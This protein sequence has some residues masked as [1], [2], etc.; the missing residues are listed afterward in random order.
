VDTKLWTGQ[1]AITFRNWDFI[2]HWSFGFSPRVRLTFQLRFHTQF[3]QSILLTG[4]HELFGNQDIARALPLEYLDPQFWRVTIS[5][6][7]HAAPDADI[8]YNYV[9]RN[10]DGSLIY[11]WGNDKVI[12]PAKVAA[13]ELLIIDS[14]NHAGFYENAF[15]T[16]PFRR[17]LLKGNH[18]EVAVP[19]PPVVTHT[20][21]VKEPLVEKGQTVCLLGNSTAL[22]NWDTT[23]PLLLGRKQDENFFTLGLDLSGEPFPI[24]Y[25]YGVYDP[26]RQAF[27]RYEEGANRVL[28]DQPGPEKA[29]V[30]NDG[31]V[32][33]PANTWKGAGVAIPVFS[34]RS[35][36]SFGVGEFTDLN[37]LVD[38]CQQVGLKL[39]QILPVNDTIATGSWKDSYP[40]AAVSAFALHPLYVDLSR[41]VE[42]SNV[43]WLNELEPERRRLNS[44]ESIDYLAV[45]SAKLDCL[46]KIYASQNEK[47]FQSEEYRTFFD[48]NKHWLVPYA[49]F[50][51]L[52][53]KY[54][55]AEFSTWPEF[56]T[57]SPKKIETLIGKAGDNA[58]MHEAESHKPQVDAGFYF[59]LQ[60]HLHCQL[61]EATEY[62]HVH[63][64][65]LKGDIPI[66]VSRN[67]A[68]VWQQ[69]ELF[70][71]DVQ[72]GAPPD[73]FAVKGQN[74]SFPTYNWPRMKQTGFAWWKHRFEQMSRYFDAFRIDHILGFFR[75][76]SIPA[77][78]VEGI[79]GRFVP[80][81]PVRLD[82]FTRCGIDLD[83]ARFTRPYIT[84]QI[85]S[86]FFGNGK[87]AV[88]DRF[89]R[90]LATGRYILKPEFATQRQVEAYFDANEQG[91]ATQKLKE[92][93]FDL[94]SNVLMFDAPSTLDPR[95]SASEFHFRFA[96][97]STSSF[98]DLDAH[99]REQ[100][101]ELYVDYFFRRQNDFWRKE[102]MEKLPA[103]KRSTNMLVCG[104]DLGLVPACVPEVMKQLGLLSLEIQRMPKEP[105]REFFHPKDA[106]YLSVVTP[107]THDMSTIRR[108]WEEDPKATQRFY[109]RELGLP[110]DAPAQCTPAINRVIVEQHLFSP[111]MWSIFQLQDLLGMDEQ[112]RRQNPA[113]E[114]INVPADPNNHWRY[115][116]HLTLEALMQARS[117]NGQ[118]K[119][120]IERAGR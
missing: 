84:E 27:L 97:E 112:L 21:K 80:A 115:R 37:R 104:E 90:Q 117:F 86:E 47:T 109:N 110:G 99:T 14:W 38:W 64:V 113:D 108:W 116:M 78:A 30:V 1:S 59:F 72:A 100:L 101:R 82:E 31:F 69:P 60:Y 22:R 6:P 20:F 46:R 44:L 50:C 114:R 68:D 106:P 61:K 35:E 88:K 74:W 42:G 120:L 107:A 55:T 96:I 8:V 71:L 33:L 66:G 28:E 18:T 65:I 56:Q 11:D 53:D 2:S 98:R 70:H 5:L 76:W 111:A 103:L 93:L 119:G 89:L 48:Q 34:L 57:Y 52:R 81:L 10:P 32:R 12:N 45:L 17:V 15:Y 9:L 58:E 49:A 102:A 91:E 40:Y 105:G 95:H 51:C 67:S 39:I 4:N 75:I 63:G 24:A 7:R 26:E 23:Q 19:T 87:E 3:G 13:E 41:V 94:I 73:A 29:T 54:G 92:G 118:L 16:E 43:R 83:K 62:A 36:R 79:L 77:D 25:K 85:L